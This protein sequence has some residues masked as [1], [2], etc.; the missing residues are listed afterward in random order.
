MSK[1]IVI[2][3]AQRIEIIRR[4][5]S[6]EELSSIQ[7]DFPMSIDVLRKNIQSWGVVLRGTRLVFTEEQQT[8]IIDRYV[9]QREDA[10]SLATA[11]KCGTTTIYRSLEKWGIE[12]RSRKNQFTKEKKIE[13]ITRYKTGEP[14]NVIASDMNCSINV[15]WRNLKEWGIEPNHP[16]PRQNLDP[17]LIERLMALYAEHKT[18]DELAEMFNVKRGVITRH[19]RE[20]GALIR[21]SGRPQ[22]FFT[23]NGKKTCG[24]CLEEKPTTEFTLHSATYDG[25]Q[26]TCNSCVKLRSKEQKLKSNF[27]ITQADYDL[28]LDCQDGLCAICHQPETRIKFGKP[29]MLAVDHDHKTGKIRQLLCSKCNMAIGL[30]N[31][32]TELLRAAALYLEKH[33]TIE[34]ATDGV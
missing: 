19:L 13:V 16:R 24:L 22:K 4:Y 27:G 1:K 15:I 33:G 11:F 6:G 26:S 12:I 5:N 29:T 31:D 2:T 25:L 9:N 7:P 30:M 3:D 28:M 14:I 8:E 20:N 18:L 32:S 17:I 34:E 10:P 21:R 23:V